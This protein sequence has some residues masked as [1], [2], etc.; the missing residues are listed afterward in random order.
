[1]NRFIFFDDHSKKLY[2]AMTKNG[3]DRKLVDAF[4]DMTR[5]L[6][7][8]RNAIPDF[9]Y[10]SLR[11]VVATEVYYVSESHG[12]MN[13][14]RKLILAIPHLTKS[15]RLSYETRLQEFT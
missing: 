13:R 1:M 9:W 7:G 10:F 2:S 15:M 11:D 6:D 3:R 12:L 4:F 8:D 5:S 14:L